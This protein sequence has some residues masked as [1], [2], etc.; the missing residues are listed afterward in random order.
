L[1]ASMSSYGVMPKADLRLRSDAQPACSK[2]TGIC[3]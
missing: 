1:I 2:N 3:C